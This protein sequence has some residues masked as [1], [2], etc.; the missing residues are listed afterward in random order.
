M[1]RERLRF[2]VLACYSGCGGC[3]LHELSRLLG[4]DLH[5]LPNWLS[6]MLFYSPQLLR[7]ILAAC[8]GHSQVEISTHGNG[9]TS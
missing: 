3:L 7:C 9:I 6:C 5:R 1:V 4:V 8:L 2:T